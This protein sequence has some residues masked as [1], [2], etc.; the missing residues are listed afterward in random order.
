MVLR[1]LI[2]DA[3]WSTLEPLLRD[4]KRKSYEPIQ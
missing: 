4:T 1:L 3:V 2:T